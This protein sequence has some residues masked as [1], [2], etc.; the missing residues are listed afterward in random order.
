MRIR[1]ATQEDLDRIYG[2][3]NLL[4]GRPMKPKPSD[5]SAEQAEQPPAA[6]PE[7]ERE[8]S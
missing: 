3:A 5:E 6:Q 8:D 4:I 2:S 1:L 7:P